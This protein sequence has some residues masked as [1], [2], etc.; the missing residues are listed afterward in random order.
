MQHYSLSRV[1]DQVELGCIGGL[2]NVY[3]DAIRTIATEGC[4]SRDATV[5]LDDIGSELRA[6]IKCGYKLILYGS[7]EVRCTCTL[8]QSLGRS[9]DVVR[10]VDGS[11]KS[12]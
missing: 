3:K 1:P 4:V 12:G 8:A 7:R 9:V 2:D 6:E 5:L 11:Q 10:C